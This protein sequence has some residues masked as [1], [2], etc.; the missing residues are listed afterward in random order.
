MKA[1]QLRGS[2][3]VELALI[4][5]L[6]CLLV[7]GSQLVAELW[8]LK[9]DVQ[10]RA[11]TALWEL[12][13]FT[14]FEP[15]EETGSLFAR[16]RTGAVRTASGGEPRFLPSALLARG[17]LNVEVDRQALGSSASVDVRLAAVLDGGGLDGRWLFRA[18]ASVTPRSLL[19]ATVMGATRDLRLIDE[20]LLFASS[21]ALSDGSDAE[22]VDGRSGV[23]ARRGQPHGLWRQVSRMTRASPNPSGES[24]LRM[25]QVKEWI[26]LG[27]VHPEAT[28]VVSRAYGRRQ[29]PKCPGLPGYPSWA[30]SGLQDLSSAPGLDHPRPACFDSAPGRD[31]ARYRD[32]LALQMLEVRGEGFLGCSRTE[33]PDPTT[34]PEGL[35]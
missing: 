6:L 31:T 33:W 19:F 10:E 23:S 28:F 27:G 25:G 13:A 30:A 5:P 17:A 1:R 34:C 20:G 16:A 21:W 3:L 15:D 18:R 12:T 4:L 9:L 8:L 26:R 7:L 24:L 35:R 11:R 2:A 14:H 32:A 22:V 29:G